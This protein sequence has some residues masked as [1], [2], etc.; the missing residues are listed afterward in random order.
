M[1]RFPNSDNPAQVLQMPF[2]VEVLQGVLYCDVLVS[3]AHCC[4][5]ML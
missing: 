5:N 1:A 2:D 3:A 4:E